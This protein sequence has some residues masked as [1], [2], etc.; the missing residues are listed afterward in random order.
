MEPP[1]L[2]DDVLVSNLGES[3]FGEHAKR[4]RVELEATP[5]AAKRL[6]LLEQHFR[7]MQRENNDLRKRW[8]RSMVDEQKRNAINV[9]SKTPRTNA[10]NHGDYITLREPPKKK[11]KK[12]GTAPA[13]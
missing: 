2:P 3:V 7:E 9:D 13:K 1:P 10:W 11:K 8:A 5:G 12:K 6:A 4:L